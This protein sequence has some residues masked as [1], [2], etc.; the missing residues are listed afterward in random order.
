MNAAL[1]TAV[2][3][4]LAAALAP[5]AVY[6]HVP[7]AVDPGSDVPFPYVTIGEDEP[8][9]WDTDTE[10]GFE[11]TFTVHVWSRQLGRLQVKQLQDEIYDALHRYNLPVTG[12]ETV[13]LSFESATTLQDPDGITQHGVSRFRGLFERV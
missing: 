13:L 4:R 9:E 10:D 6:D 7:Q 2:F 12:Y 8:R 1:Q 5:V 3:T 11:A